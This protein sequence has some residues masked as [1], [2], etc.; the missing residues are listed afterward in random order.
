MTV[1]YYYYYYLGGIFSSC[2]ATLLNIRFIIMNDYF[3]L[4]LS[5]NFLSI[6]PSR[7]AASMRRNYGTSLWHSR[8]SLSCSVLGKEGLLIKHC[9]GPAYL[10]TSSDCCLDNIR[11]EPSAHWSDELNPSFQKKKKIPSIF[12]SIRLLKA[13]QCDPSA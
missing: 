3:P 7:W 13:F 6:T 10:G 12:R 4:H 1:P 11:L 5:F 8:D 9:A 2:Y